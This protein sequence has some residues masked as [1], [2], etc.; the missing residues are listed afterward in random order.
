MR[1]F[2]DSRPGLFLRLL[3][4]SLL[5]SIAVLPAGQSLAEDFSDDFDDN[6]KNKGLWG[7][8]IVDGIGFLKEKN[9]RLEYTVSSPNP[10]D[11]ILR[12]LYGGIGPY[13]T[14]WETKIDLFNSTNPASNK[15]NSYGIS[16]IRCGSLQHELFA[17]LYAFGGNGGN[18]FSKG[19][20][21]A[22]TS[23]AAL[24]GDADTLDLG[25]EPL[26]GSLRIAFDSIF[27]VFAVFY[28]TGGG[29]V[30]LALFNVNGGNGGLNGTGNWGMTDANEFCIGVYGYSNNMS[31]SGGKVYGDN[32]SAT[33]LTPDRVILLQPNGGDVITP[34]PLPYVIQWIAPPDAQTFKLQLSVDNGVT[35]SLIADSVPGPTYSWMVDPPSKNKKQCLVKVTAFNGNNAKVGSDKSD[36]AF[37]I[38]VLKLNSPNG[39]EQLTSNVTHTIIWTTNGTSAPVDHIVLSYTLNNGETWKTIDTSGDPFDDGSFDWLVPSVN[40]S[41]ERSKVKIVLKDA[42]GNTVG[43]DVSDET[44]T[45]SPP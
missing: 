8:D 3:V 32:F 12:P 33:G 20:Y 10:D 43:N 17:E 7:P 13:S 45:I 37:T 11:F 5:F 31:I 28:D 25:I 41:K 24:S 30:P 19:F 4:L 15:Y 27:K 42:Q 14:D 9:G 21:T 44:F 18:P 39:G 34:G 2:A 23:Q 35:W 6:V 36:S 22:L 38:E 40:G 26:S 29:E 1:S 16:I